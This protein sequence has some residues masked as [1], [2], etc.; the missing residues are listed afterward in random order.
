MKLTPRQLVAGFTIC[1]IFM[2]GAAAIQSS[3]APPIPV[4]DNPESYLIFAEYMAARSSSVE[5]QRAAVESALLGASSAVQHGDLSF[6]ATCL[7]AAAEFAESTARADMWD[8]AVMLDP[9]RMSE[10]NS[11]RE[12]YDQDA[13][14]AGTAILFA[15]YNRSDLSGS[16]YSHGQVQIA[17]TRSALQ[18]GYSG[19]EVIREID[20][21]ARH[22]QDDDCKG[23]V[24]VPQRDS[25]SNQIIRVLCEDH[26][27]P[28]GAMRDDNVFVML[29]QTEMAL[30]NVKSSAWAAGQG[31]GNNPPLRD[32]SLVV[33]M[34]S[35]GI[36]DARPLWIN[37]R[38]SESP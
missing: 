3:A 6:A 13:A 5:N 29:L 24:F 25:N 35:Y 17:I 15:R 32:P 2:A 31:S 34:E 30:R 38:W 14:R 33:L 21:V 4:S 18:A 12:V 1:A 36:S 37:G 8:L 19:D 9:T 27:R 10:W 11:F 20:R 16:E 28:L 23:R 22:A 7:I 26:N